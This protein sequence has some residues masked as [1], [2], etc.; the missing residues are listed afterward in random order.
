[1]ENIREL[2]ISP[3]YC[4]AETTS[5]LSETEGVSLHVGGFIYQ[6]FQAIT[7]LQNF[8]NVLNHDI[9]HLLYNHHK[10][11]NYKSI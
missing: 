6:Q 5:L 9:S 1:L 2:D 3:P 4:A 11:G 8:V 10:F 7:S